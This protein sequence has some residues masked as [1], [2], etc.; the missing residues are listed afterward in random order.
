MQNYAGHRRF[1]KKI[2]YAVLAI[3]LALFIAIGARG[4]NKI[5]DM[6]VAAGETNRIVSVPD[7]R[8]RKLLQLQ[9]NAF[10]AELAPAT[11]PKTKP[12]TSQ[13]H[14]VQ[15]VKQTAAR[16]ETQ[17]KQ[18]SNE[19]RMINQEKTLSSLRQSKE[20]KL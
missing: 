17:G 4:I 12:T 10:D 11:S 18:A 13:Q 6:A 19:D 5:D 2:E 14:L 9:Q 8:E 15:A 3:G 7:D 16:T 20:L 1:S